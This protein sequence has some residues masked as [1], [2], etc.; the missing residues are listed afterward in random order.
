MVSIE[1]IK[2]IVRDEFH[3]T[4]A[5]LHYPT[6]GKALWAAARQMVMYLHHTMNGA[7]LRECAAH[8]GRDPTTAGEAV[9]KIK[10]HINSPRVQ[11]CIE[12]AKNAATPA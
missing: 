8:F 5:Q 12:A 9:I 1:I 2:R 11:K 10:M 7:S 4:D 6:R 3:V